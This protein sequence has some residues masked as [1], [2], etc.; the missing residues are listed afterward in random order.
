[1]Y[2]QNEDKTNDGTAN[3]GCS[4]RQMKFNEGLA[5]THMT[6]TLVMRECFSVADFGVYNYL[7][8]NAVS[9]FLLK[10]SVIKTNESELIKGN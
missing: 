7:D 1:M 4:I 2:W 9:D 8:N 3:I 6:H 5:M 10:Y